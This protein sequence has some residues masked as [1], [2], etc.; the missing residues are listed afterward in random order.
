ME[1]LREELI[2][3]TEELELEEP[4]ETL[5]E[6]EGIK[7]NLHALE[8]EEGAKWSRCA[9]YKWL[10]EGNKPSPFF[11]RLQN[12]KRK[13]ERILSIRSVDGRLLT[14]EQ[15][16]MRELWGFYVALFQADARTGEANR[17]RERILEHSLD[18]L[19]NKDRQRLKAVL[20]LEEVKATL[21]KL[22]LGKSLGLDRVT[23]EVLI[24][25]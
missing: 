11:F 18:K 4:L 19:S 9:R 24:A 25:C 20:V 17:A 14:E 6:W 13:R 22:P 5:Q 7:A 1:L 23:V 3:L 21:R 2:A 15:D 10:Q 16:I 12:D 8:M